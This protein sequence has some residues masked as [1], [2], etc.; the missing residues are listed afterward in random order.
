MLLAGDE[1][2]RT[3]QGNNNA[4]CQDNE[5]SWLDWA[6]ADEDLLRFTA[7]LIEFRHEHP[8]LRRKRFFQGRPIR[9]QGVADIEWLT[10]DGVPMEDEF[11][12]KPAAHSIAILLRGDTIPDRDGRGEPVV[13]DTFYVVFN[14][15]AEDRQALLP[16]LGPDQ[17]WDLILDTAAEQPM[18]SQPWP[19][20]G[21]TRV[22]VAGRS[23]VL[24]RRV[25]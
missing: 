14:G 18:P 8:V 17:R 13:D 22:P 15:Y 7:R 25:D 2:G 3:Q 23:V 21:G 16:R 5:L 1:I 4:Y 11:W 19:F 10:L 9:G 12:E 6:N 24:L 20:R